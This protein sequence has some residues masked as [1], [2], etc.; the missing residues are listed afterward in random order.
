M[1]N[2]KEKYQQRL[3]RI[4]TAIALK[5]PDRMPITPW[6]D[7]LPYFLYPEYGVTYKTALYDIEKA[8]EPHI[9]YHQEFEPDC[10]TTNTIPLSGRAADFLHPTMIEWPGRAGSPLSDDTIHQMLEIEYLKV[11]E[12]DELLSD[13]TGFILHKYLPRSFAGLAGLEKMEIDPSSCIM[14]RAL[15]PFAAPEVLEALKKIIQYGEERAAVDKAYS[16]FIEKMRKLG[17]P[18]FFSDDGEVPFDVLSDFF[19]GT[20]GTLY[21]QVERPKKIHAACE[22]FARIQIEKF[23]KTMS[24][25]TDVKRVF[26]PMHKGMDYFI[27]DEQ[28]RDL[29]WAPY[30]KILRHLIGMGVTPII[31]TEGQYFTRCEFIR[32]QLTEFPLGSCMIHFEYGDFAELKKIFSGV[33]CIFGGMPMQLLEYGTKTEVIERVKYLAENCAAGGGFI[34]DAS[35]TI[36]RAKRENIEVMFDTARSL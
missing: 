3:T 2:N 24:K 32:E 5:E 10:N 27:G 21:D 26:F 15:R 13:Y 19:R 28:C 16:I 36:D 34:L 31:Y 18:P 8:M 23:T 1:S 6:V 11:D 7:G 12:Y 9:R 35:G 22:K 33:A 17:Y 29:Y 30:Q 20:M 25:D 14:D 4:E